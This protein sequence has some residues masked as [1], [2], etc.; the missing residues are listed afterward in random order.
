MMSTPW[1]GINP[2]ANR[3]AEVAQTGHSAVNV[4]NG[5]HKSTKSRTSNAAFATKKKKKKKKEGR[6]P[7]AIRPFATVLLSSISPAEVR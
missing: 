4:R 6:S 1:I 2:T 7:L 5:V 3:A